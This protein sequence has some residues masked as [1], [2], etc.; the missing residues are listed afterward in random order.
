MENECAKRYGRY[1]YLEGRIPVL[2]E[3]I[4]NLGESLKVMKLDMDWKEIAVRNLEDPGFLDRLLGRVERKKEK[5]MSEWR[6]VKATYEIA[7]RKMEELEYQRKQE[8][9]ELTSLAESRE[10]YEQ[11]GCPKEVEA[12][13]PAALAAAE[14]CLE[15]LQYMLPHARRDVRTTYVHTGNRKMEF[16]QKAAEHA[17]V[18][19]QVLGLMPEGIAQTGSYFQYPEHYITAVTS[20]Y[21]Q[22][23]RVEMAMNQVREVRKK[24]RELVE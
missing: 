15:A 22:L 19:T 10:E 18:L 16:M 20:E 1:L 24:L 4:Q 8:K 21:A 5:A 13:A 23:D 17:R 11:A 12:F 3:Q 9:E 6:D 2:E 7:K 14:R